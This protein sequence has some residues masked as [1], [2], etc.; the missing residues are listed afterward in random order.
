MHV[1]RQLALLAVLGLCCG[2]GPVAADPGPGGGP[3]GAVPRQSLA[4]EVYS[5]GFHVLAVDI[6]VATAPDHYDLVARVHTTGL[7]SWL[8]DWRQVSRSTGVLDGAAV[9]PQRH[10]ADGE[11]RGRPR[12]VAIDYDGGR[13]AAVTVDPPPREDEDREEVSPQLRDGTLDPLS[14]I[15]AMVRAVSDGRGCNRRVAVFD[16][17]RRYDLVF[18]D[19]GI[20][21]VPESQYVAASAVMRECDFVFEPIAGEVRRPADPS[22][23]RKLRSGRAWIAPAAPGALAAPMRVELDGNWGTTVAYLRDPSRAGPPEPRSGSPRRDVAPN[24]P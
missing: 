17:R 4:Y 19:R 6:D 15:F 13:V 2:I 9:E 7:L 5:A 20:R 23:D 11:L 22:Q 14:A 1:R 12:R 21:P 24:T 18:T 10:R 8:I 3:A 16:G